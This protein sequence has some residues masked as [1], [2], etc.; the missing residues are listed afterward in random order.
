MQ[1]RPVD[2]PSFDTWTFSLSR[3]LPFGGGGTPLF[4]SQMAARLD[5]LRRASLD[6]PGGFDFPSDARRFDGNPHGQQ[7]SGGDAVGGRRQQP[8][9]R[10]E[11]KA[12]LAAAAR[13]FLSRRC[14]ASLAAA[15]PSARQQ[16]RL[17]Q[18]LVS[19]Y[20]CRHEK[21]LHICKQSQATA[22]V[23]VR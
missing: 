6:L 5:S 3:S 13:E 20:G 15:G 1:K 14:S 18:A 17:S 12:L 4:L 11:A 22:L 21:C 7:Q 23:R 19:M 9:G 8:Q 16:E 2:R 10:G